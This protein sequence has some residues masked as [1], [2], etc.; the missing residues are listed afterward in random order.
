MPLELTRQDG[1][2][3]L[4]LWGNVDIFD[5]MSLHGAALEAAQGPAPALV[6]RLDELEALD[7]SGT[8][9]LLALRRALAGEGR[10]MRI[11][12]VPAAVADGWRLLGLEADLG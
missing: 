10:T 9:V 11:E 12:G 2:W 1:E 8:Q 6:V 5:A 3:S 7:T 4:R